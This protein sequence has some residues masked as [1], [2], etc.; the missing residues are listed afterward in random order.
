MIGLLPAGGEIGYENKLFSLRGQIG[1]L[2]FSIGRQGGRKVEMEGRNLLERLKISP[3]QRILLKTAYTTLCQM[4]P[5]VWIE[6]LKIHITVGGRDPANTAMLYGVTGAALE[7]LHSC[8]DE[9]TGKED[10]RAEADFSRVDT[11]ISFRI[12]LFLRLYL[13]LWCA[14][15]ILWRAWRENQRF[16]KGSIGKDDE[17]ATG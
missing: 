12:C 6:T 17:S 2:R 7:A 4:S 15:R 8:F 9:C 10:L 5:R 16:S 14:L 13:A 1:F 11:E 3:R